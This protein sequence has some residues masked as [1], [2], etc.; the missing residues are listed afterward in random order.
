MCII[1]KVF[2]RINLSIGIIKATT[3]LM[4]ILSQSS[5]LPWILLVIQIAI[6][7]VTVAAAMFALSV[8]EIV[9]IDAKS[10]NA[11]LLNY[12][13]NFKCRHQWR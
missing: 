6:G 9:T 11:T 3:K 10:N 5:F 12:R 4:K 8:G 7:A 1:M 13:S 2:N